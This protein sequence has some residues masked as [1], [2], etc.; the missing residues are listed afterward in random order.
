MTMPLDQ[1]SDVELTATLQRIRT[2]RAEAG[3][4]RRKILGRIADRVLD[5]VNE[6]RGVASLR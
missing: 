4:Q 1:M 2:E 3:E 5:E 6:R